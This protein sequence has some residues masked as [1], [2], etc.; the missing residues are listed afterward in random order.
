MSERVGRFLCS[1]DALLA[2]FCRRLGWQGAVAVAYSRILRRDPDDED[3]VSRLAEA[4]CE[5]GRRDE[6]L[7]V[8]GRCVSVSPTARLV[9]TAWV[10]CLAKP[11]TTR[12][13]WQPSGRR[14]GSIP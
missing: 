6:A 12:S 8:L 1:A 9:T 3:A 4:L 13:Q 11:A 5:L 14:S 10:G 2:A 7:K